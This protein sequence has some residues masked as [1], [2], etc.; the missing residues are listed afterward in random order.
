MF[1]ETKFY[2]LYMSR[3]SKT[4]LLHCSFLLTGVNVLVFIGYLIIDV[5]ENVVIFYQLTVLALCYYCRHTVWESAVH[6]FI[7]LN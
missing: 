2:T 1:L 6:I 7:L 5:R 4:M 3:I